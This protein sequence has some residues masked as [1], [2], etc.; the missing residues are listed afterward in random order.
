M[1]QPQ[2]STR[3]ETQEMHAV[4]PRIELTSSERFINRELS[5]LEFNMRVLAEAKNPANPLLERARFLSISASNLDEFYMVRAAGLTG[6]VAAKI[7]ERSQDGMT[8]LEQL[9]AIRAKVSELL[10]GQDDC[11]AKLLEEC[12]A[13]GV[14][15][16]DAAA[17]N[18]EDHD[19]L[20]S[21]FDKQVFPV[22]TPL[23]VD[24]AHPFPF[25]QNGSVVFALE[26]RREMDEKEMKG[27]IIIPSQI[28]RF[29][30]LPGRNIRFVTLLIWVGYSPVSMLRVAAC[31]GSSVIAKLR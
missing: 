24:P 8:P 9:N 31:S 10:D 30:R 1:S 3:R 21:W 15:V 23:A 26:L 4:A 14:E 13:S 17:L 25:I 16:A 6:Q 29:V 12:K 11:L 7:T 20:V 22:I 27:L 18:A 28:D 19:W 5:W 2:Q